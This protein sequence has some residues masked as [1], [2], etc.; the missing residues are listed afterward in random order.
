MVGTSY[1]FSATSEIYAHP[2]AQ[3]VCIFM[4]TMLMT[5]P[6]RAREK[7]VTS[8][9]VFAWLMTH[10]TLTSVPARMTVTQP[11][12]QS[13]HNHATPPT[14]CS[15]HTSETAGWDRETAYSALVLALALFDLRTTAMGSP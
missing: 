1:N 14:G 10:A 4:N 12:V 15:A 6:R 11:H 2:T 8:K 9:L 13:I 5:H 3:A 7:G